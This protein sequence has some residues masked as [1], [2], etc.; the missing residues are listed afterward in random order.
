M[1]LQILSW[2]VASY[3]GIAIFFFCGVCWF[4]KEQGAT[5]EGP[6]PWRVALTLFWLTPVAALRPRSS[7]E[8]EWRNRGRRRCLT[9]FDL[10][11]RVAFRTRAVFGRMGVL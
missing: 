2:V 1:T 8:E 4:L 9:N 5:V 7:P 3:V 10:C 6:S 11:E